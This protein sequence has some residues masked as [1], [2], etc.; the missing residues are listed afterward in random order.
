MRNLVRNGEGTPPVDI[1]VLSLGLF[2]L[3]GLAFWSA[4]ISQFAGPVVED[5]VSPQTIAGI[6]F[7]LVGVSCLA[8]SIAVY[9]RRPIGWLGSFLA[10]IVAVIVTTVG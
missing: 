6:Q 2:G 8:L 9:Q 5:G 3:G 4:F 10:G 7:G 1:V